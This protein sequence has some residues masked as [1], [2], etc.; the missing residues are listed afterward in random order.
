M[1]SQLF[2]HQVER[3]IPAGSISRHPVNQRLSPG[4]KRWEKK[5][6]E[7][8]LHKANTGRIHVIAS[9]THRNQYLA[10]DGATRTED[11]IA[12]ARFGPKTLLRCVVY[13]N[14]KPPSSP[15]LSELFLFLNTDRVSVGGTVEHEQGVIA[16][17]PLHLFADTL[18]KQL[19]PKFRG[20]TGVVNLVR[21]HGEKI[22]QQAVTEAQKIWGANQHIPV[23]VLRAVAL[24]L[25][26]PADAQRL[27]SRR[28]ALR[29]DSPANWEMKAKNKMLREIGQRDSLQ[30]YVVRGLLGRLGR[31]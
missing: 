2:Q 23:I 19:G 3:F 7:F 27:A 16:Q 20:R 17:R 22:A 5:C 26:K 8:D 28:S 29:K 13:G 18:L 9:P 10:L 21:T 4:I 12:D 14:G 1:S 6:G 25:H 11:C 31:G 15:E 24:I 30:K